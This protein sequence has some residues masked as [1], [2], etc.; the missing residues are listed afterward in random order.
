MDPRELRELLELWLEILERGLN[1]QL[2]GLALPSWLPMPDWG[3][4]TGPTNPA[5]K[6][7]PTASCGSSGGAHVPPTIPFQG[8][9]EATGSDIGGLGNPPLA[10]G[11]W[12]DSLPTGTGITSELGPQGQTASLAS[13]SR[14]PDNSF[15]D[16]GNSPHTPTAWG[17]AAMAA[18]LPQFDGKSC[19]QANLAQFNFIAEAAG[20]SWQEKGIN[21]AASMKGDALQALMDISGTA[22]GQHNAAG[23]QEQAGVDGAPPVCGQEHLDGKRVGCLGRN[24]NSIYV[25]CEVAGTPVSALIDT[26]SNISLVQRGLLAGST[27]WLA[28]ARTAAVGAER[29]R[30]WVLSFNGC[31]RGKVLWELCYLLV[32]LA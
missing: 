13:T 4:S 20:W 3:L 6:S 8:A 10:P 16:K 17:K 7:G 1:T 29:S 22:S 19:W 11:E 9:G 23:K 32:L 28:T 5:S 24:D 25:H 30:N 27:P 26:G 21:L 15:T 31:G 18:K 2:A 12:N 14:A